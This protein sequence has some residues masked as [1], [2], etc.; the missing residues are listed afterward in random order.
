MLVLAACVQYG[1]VFDFGQRNKGCEILP[2][3]HIFVCQNDLLRI[4]R[5]DI[6]RVGENRRNFIRRTETL[7][8]LIIFAECQDAALLP[9]IMK[10]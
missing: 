9:E 5:G 3:H 4:E 10:A 2:H 7:K 8:H 1:K 6:V